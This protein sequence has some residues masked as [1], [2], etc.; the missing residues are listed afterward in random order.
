MNLMCGGII[1]HGLVMKKYDEIIIEDE[2]KDSEL[3]A[4]TT[5]QY[6]RL[7]KFQKIERFKKSRWYKTAIDN[8]KS[9]RK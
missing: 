8:V 7:S 2:L 9:Y 5:K 4:L 3:D 6:R 1:N